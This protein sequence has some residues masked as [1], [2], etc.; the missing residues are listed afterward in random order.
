MNRSS[1]SNDWPCLAILI[2][3][4]LVSA[5]VSA[6]TY[7][8]TKTDDTHDLVC[9]ADCSLREAIVAANGTSEVDT[10]MVPAGTYTFTLSGADE[11]FAATGDLDI[12]TSVIITGAG[13][14]TTII[15]AAGLDRVFNLVYSGI[16]VTI[17][18]VTITGGAGVMSGGGVSINGSTLILSD[19]RV[20]D[21]HVTDSGGGIGASSTSSVTI[22]NGSMIA[23]NSAVDNCGGGITLYQADLTVTDST[24]SGNSG[25]CAG[26][27]WIQQADATITGSTISGNSATGA[28][29][30]GAGL[31]V[32]GATPTEVALINTTIVNNHSAGMAGAVEIA[33]AGVVSMNSVTLHGNSSGTTEAPD[34]MVDGSSELTLTNTLVSDSCSVDGTVISGGANLESP[35]DTCGLTAEDDLHVTDAMLFGPGDFGGVTRTVMPTPESPAVDQGASCSGVDQRGL[36][37]PV[38]PCDIGAVERRTG[39]PLFADDFES[40]GTGAWSAVF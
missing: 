2:V 40:G 37:R 20:I 32:H 10:V 26:G 3:F 22:E 1:K 18:G 24:V 35:G 36:P 31:S 30:R 25:W 27:L 15:D 16:T 8:V 7:T 9:A 13:P 33:G 4:P 23:D 17:S 28:V 29:G 6:T 21:N 5:T 39:D 19:C 11:D 38:G 14:E 34:I 12:T